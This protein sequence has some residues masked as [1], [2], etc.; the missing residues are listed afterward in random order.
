[1][2][3]EGETALNS[4]IGNRQSAIP[5]YRFP[6]TLLLRIAISVARERPRSLGA[7]SAG[8]L[9]GATPRPVA[10]ET[11]HLPASGPFI[12]VGNH[13]ERPGM[14]AQWGAMV[15]NAA[16]RETGAE[17]RELHWL[18]AAEWVNFR[19]GPFRV[20]P[21]WTHTVFTRFAR[22][23]GFGLVSARETGAVGGSSGLRIAARSLAAGQPVG[24]LPEGTASSQLIEARPGVGVGLEW[25]ARGGIPLV[26]VGIA[27]LDGV[28]T[29]RFGPPF[30]L[31]PIAGDRDARDRQLRDAVMETIAL[32]LPSELRGYYREARAES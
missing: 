1:M 14:F 24:I 4:A 31:P 3:N 16:V 15:V 10:L 2:R 5:R 6:K 25:L 8:G 7:D 17:P 21:T 30:H 9:R 19:V 20:P 22:V 11:H 23:Y 27:E 32:L 18:I 26:P 29:A 12:V 13:Y 28:L